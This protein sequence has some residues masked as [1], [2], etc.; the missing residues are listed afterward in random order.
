MSFFS[1][2]L[3]KRLHLHALSAQRMGSPLLAAVRR[4]LPGGG[5][6]ATGH[7]EYASGDDFHAIDWDIYARR[8]DLLVKQ[9][10]GHADR[11]VHLLLDCSPSMGLGTPA[12]FQLARQIAA[13]LGYVSLT[14]NDR[15]VVAAFADGLKADLPPLC[16][17]SRLPRLLRFLEELTPCGAK[18][19][20]LRAAHEFVRR[21]QRN[22]PVIVISDLYDPDGF[23]RGFDLLRFYGYE[24]R[25]VHIFDPHDAEPT[26]LGDRELVDIESQSVLQGT[27]TERTVRRYRQLVAEFHATVRDYCSRQSIVYLPIACDAPED[28]VLKQVLGVST[29]SSA[30]ASV[31]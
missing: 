15:L 7:R 5:M 28:E 11:N 30:K 21:P 26:F 14:T 23:Q 13:A 22:G 3:L 2:G 1:A 16:H 20:L 4:T 8:G 25:M 31:V 9:F 17:A 27:V 12:K 6:E 10:E 29:P 19:D 24:P 18:T